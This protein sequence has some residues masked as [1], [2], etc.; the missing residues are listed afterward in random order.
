MGTRAETRKNTCNNSTNR[1]CA[2][3]E[4]G[5]SWA[6]NANRKSELSCTL[7]VETLS[8]D[9]TLDGCKGAKMERHHHNK[10]NITNKQTRSK[11]ESESLWG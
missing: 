7:G 11:N 3:N 5:C 8:T 4:Q 6:D 2:G 9:P 10:C 1:M